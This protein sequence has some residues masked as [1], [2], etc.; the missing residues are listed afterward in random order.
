MVAVSGTARGIDEAADLGVSRGNQHVEKT[1]DVRLVGGDRVFD[2]ARHA[3]K[4]RLMKHIIDR[5]RKTASAILP[6]HGL[7]TVFQNPDVAFDKVKQGF[8]FAARPA[9]GRAGIR[10]GRLQIMPMAGGKVVEADDALAECQ[11]GFQQ[12]AADEAGHAGDQ[13]G[14]RLGL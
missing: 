11:Q 10:H 13:P 2:G 6:G 14:F 4:R 5:D 8:Q 7:P 3:A 1:V 12:V 9:G